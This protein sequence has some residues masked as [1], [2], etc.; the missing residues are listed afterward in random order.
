MITK[1]RPLEL[2]TIALPGCNMNSL[3][4]AINAPDS[5]R[6]MRMAVNGFLEDIAYASEELK[7]FCLGELL[8]E[9]QEC[10]RRISELP[11]QVATDLACIEIQS[12]WGRR[13]GARV[14]A[15]LMMKHGIELYPSYGTCCTVVET[16]TAAHKFSIIRGL[17]VLGQAHLSIQHHGLTNF[18]SDP[19]LPPRFSTAAAGRVVRHFSYGVNESIL[20]DLPLE[21]SIAELA[22][23]LR[24]LSGRKVEFSA[25]AVFLEKCYEGAPHLTRSRS[26][27]SKSHAGAPVDGCVPEIDRLL[28]AVLRPPR[29]RQSD[30]DTG[31]L[32]F[33]GDSGDGTGPVGGK[34]DG[35]RTSI[36]TRIDD[37]IVTDDRDAVLREMRGSRKGVEDQRQRQAQ[38]I[39]RL[40]R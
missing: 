18:R 22:K 32:P 1:P 24:G 27:K 2:L 33:G 25:L 4:N 17:Y 6:G 31:S 26:G 28:E 8:Q 14:R 23:Y 30:S 16:P 19:F 34:K 39:H 12:K 38:D 10:A 21:D 13:R 15:N 5:Y 11:S 3:T 7:C 20:H 35:D 29:P 37:F 36:P 40:R 9:T